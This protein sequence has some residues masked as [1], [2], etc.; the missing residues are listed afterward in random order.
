MIL[1][2]RLPVPLQIFTHL[3]S[4]LLKKKNNKC[5]NRCW[6]RQTFWFLFLF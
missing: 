6:K 1:Q 4:L 2:V 3:F 5:L